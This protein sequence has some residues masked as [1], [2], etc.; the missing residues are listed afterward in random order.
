MA[1]KGHDVNLF[2]SAP[3]GTSSE[4]TRSILAFLG[5]DGYAFLSHSI[6]DQFD[7]ESSPTTACCLRAGPPTHSQKAVRHYDS[8]R[9]NH[10]PV[11]SST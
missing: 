9:R 6:V 4:A 3:N 8:N 7:P 11:A 5:R 1:P 2:R 10:Q